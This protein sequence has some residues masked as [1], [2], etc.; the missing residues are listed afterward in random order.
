[1]AA[2]K[3]TGLLPEEVEYL[4]LD[5]YDSPNYKQ[6]GR[7]FEEAY[8]LARI[9]KQPAEYDGPQRYCPKRAS[10]KGN[11]PR[12]RY[13]GAHGPKNG[14]PENLEKYAGLKHSMYARHETIRETLTDEEQETFDW[15]MQWPELYDIDLSA[16]PGAEDT[17]YALALEIVR[18]DRGHDYQLK[19]MVVKREGV[20]TPQGQLLEEKEMPAPLWKEMQSQIKLIES[21]KDSL[22]ISRK[23]RA[24][25]EQ[26]ENRTDVIESLSEAL[27]G[28]VMDS[29]AEYDPEQFES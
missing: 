14:T 24:K 9:G 10:R 26:T 23:E 27:G 17:F 1:M 21:L 15:V 7:P 13:H 8:C 18:R 25:H 28:L 12:C 20:Y 3:V 19:N 11:H 2:S 29:G 22:G 16:D 5:Y 6:E 4:R